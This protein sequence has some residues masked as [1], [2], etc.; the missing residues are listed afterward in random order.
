MAETT[1]NSMNTPEHNKRL[2]SQHLKLSESQKRSSG[3]VCGMTAAVVAVLMLF[4]TGVQSQAPATLKQCHDIEEASERLAC[5]DRVSDRADAVIF[6]SRFDSGTDATPSE[7]DTSA[8]VAQSSLLEAAWRLNPESDRYPIG[9]YHAN[10][11]LPLTYSNDVNNKPF[12]PVFEGADIPDQQLDSTEAKF[13]LSLKARVWSTDDRRWSLWLAYTQ[14]NQWQVY[15]EEISRPFRETNYMPELFMSYHTDWQIAGLNLK[16][17]NFGYT[18]QSN[19]RADP[20]SRSWDRIFAEVG[21]ERHNLVMMLR[22]W[23][24]ID[25]SEDKDDN[26]DITDFYGY[27]ELNTFYRWQ[28]NTFSLMARGNL[29]TGKGAVRLG[30]FSRPLIGPLRGYVQV[31]SGYGESMIDYNWNQTT[32]GIGLALHD[33]LLKRIK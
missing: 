1:L 14:Q 8:D 26:P 10:Y 11:I 31:F 30:W 22:L 25:E 29:D 33:G 32:I 5:Y 28:D 23:T 13:Q 18:H 16:L 17:I 12:S 20:I 3:S 7:S 21:L 4:S 27:S 15:N 6:S 2:C 9:M 19:G 24:R